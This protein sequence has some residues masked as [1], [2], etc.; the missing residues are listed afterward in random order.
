MMIGEEH[1][2]TSTTSSRVLFIES[3][4]NLNNKV[5]DII[6]TI[7]VIHSCLCFFWLVYVSVDLIKLLRNKRSES[8]MKDHCDY[9]AF[10][11]NENIFRNVIFLMFLA[12]EL[13]YSLSLNTHA[14]I[15]VIYQP[16]SINISIGSNCSFDSNSFIGKTYDIRMTNIF[17]IVFN[18]LCDISFSMMI[19]LFGASLLHLSFAARNQMRVKTIL[20]F[21]LFGII[22]NF[23]ISI[24]LTLPM[25]SLF[26]FI[27]H[28]IMNQISILIVIYI[29]K[30]KFFPAM[31]SRVIDA[32]H[33]HNTKVYLQQKRLLK[34]YKVLVVVFSFAFE[35]F[36]FTGL[37]FENI[38]A[39][40]N[41]VC[42]GICWFNVNYHIPMLTL[43]EST[44][45]ILQQ[46]GYFCVVSA[47]LIVLVAY[48]N[49]IVVNLNFIYVI[50]RK[51]MKRKFTKIQYRYNVCSDPL[52][53]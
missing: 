32:F 14:F 34:Q 26:G 4:N 23:I 8:I 13:V 5:F 3:L 28:S 37:F 10:I 39:I 12:G 40:F 46:I 43:S 11:L 51:S 45:G 53:S 47:N 33:L 2:F 35:L 50:T 7:A 41:T 9:K 29:A 44:L 48:L 21:I 17:L 20:K 31:N 1:N 52:L 19:W 38:Y 30:K 42:F 15:I 49:I 6:Q 18:F 36:A 24:F 22:V 25:T 27:V 16:T